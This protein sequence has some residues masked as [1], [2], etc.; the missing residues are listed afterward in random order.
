[1][2]REFQTANLAKV[3]QAPITPI[4][5]LK[6]TGLGS[7]SRSFVDEQNGQ[8]IGGFYFPGVVAHLGA[9]SLQ[10]GSVRQLAEIKGPMKYKVTT[11]AL[12]VQ[13]GKL[14]YT[15]DNLYFRDLMELDLQTGKTR[16]LIED[17]RIGDLA[18][19][20]RDGSLWGLRHLN[21]YVTLVR[22][23]PPFTGW[24]QVFTF[25]YGQILSDLDISPDGQLL[26]ATMED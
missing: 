11:P 7:V 6:A 9:M 13:A 16:M 12:D 25:P 15:A 3:R 14:Y 8:M 10:D 1:F 2:E 20:S 5:R 19:N 18:F 22:L 4:Q 21:S 24:N 17:A 26:S 23:N